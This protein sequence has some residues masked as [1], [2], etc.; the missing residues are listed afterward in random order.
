[1]VKFIEA[2]PWRLTQR[3]YNMQAISFNPKEL[4]EAIQKVIPTFSVCVYAA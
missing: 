1:M 2:E 3:T 4:T